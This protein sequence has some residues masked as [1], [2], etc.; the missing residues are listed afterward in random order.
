MKLF[1]GSSHIKIYD[2]GHEEY[3]DSWNITN[4]D[5]I[6]LF[7]CPKCAKKIKIEVDKDSNHIVVNVVDPES[8]EVIRRIPDE[9]FQALAERI[10]DFQRLF[11]EG[12]K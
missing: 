5:K 12:Q 9:K 10:D 2:N 4:T 8:G 7:C 6:A 3:F 11:L 1:G